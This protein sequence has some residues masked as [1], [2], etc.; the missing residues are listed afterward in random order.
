MDEWVPVSEDLPQIEI[1]RQ[2]VS[3]NV[4]AKLD[5]GGHT[6]A[7]YCHKDGRW[8]SV[9]GKQQTGVVAWKSLP[10]KKKKISRSERRFMVYAP[11]EYE[12]WREDCRKADREITGDCGERT[13][14]RKLREKEKSRPAVGADRNGTKKNNLT[15]L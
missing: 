2:S 12:R 13:R 10:E 11:G 15:Q 14:I 5:T 8:Y 7:Y 6:E 4:M 3:V 9:A 1:G